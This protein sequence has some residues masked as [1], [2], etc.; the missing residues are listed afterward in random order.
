MMVVI[1]LAHFTIIYSL[2]LWPKDKVLA[3]EAENA[4]SVSPGTQ[5]KV[6]IHDGHNLLD[7][8]HPTA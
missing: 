1:L 5:Q 8:C 4:R 7:Y 6:L 3:S 2:F